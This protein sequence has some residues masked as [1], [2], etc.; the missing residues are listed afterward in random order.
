MKAIIILLF[1]FIHS[2]NID[3]QIVFEKVYSLNAVGSGMAVRQTTDGGFIFCGIGYSLLGGNDHEIFLVK[4]DSIGDTLWT[5]DF[6]TAFL[7]DRGHCVEQTIDGGYI[8]TGM[9]MDSNYMDVETFLIKTD[10]YGDTI[11]TKRYKAPNDMYGNSVVQTP[12]G[13]FV[14]AGRAHGIFAL[15]TNSFGDLLWMKIFQG[16]FLDDC[17]CCV[18]TKDGGLMLTGCIYEVGSG[19]YLPFLLKLDSL[20]N[21]LWAKTYNGPK[22]QLSHYV[23]QT[24]DGGFIL[25]GSSRD[26]LSASY[27]FLLKTDSIGNIS[28]AKQFDVSEPWKMGTAVQQTFDGGYIIATGSPIYHVGN[29]D[30]CLLKTD[31][32]GQLLWSKTYDVTLGEYFSDVRQTSDSGFIIIGFTSYSIVTGMC[33]IKTDQFGNSVCKQS[34]DAIINSYNLSFTTSN[35]FTSASSYTPQELNSNFYVKSGSEFFD[36]CPFGYEEPFANNPLLIFPNPSSGTFSLLLFTN[37]IDAKLEIFN[38]M[39]TKI[40]EEKIIGS[41][42][43]EITLTGM[44][45]AIYLLKV[46]DGHKYYHQKLMLECN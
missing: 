20:G 41:V 11:W 12:D 42:K 15:K 18:N 39:G 28:W 6:G 10:A 17:Y 19:D 7:Y 26:S 2:L 21:K 25:T 43:N 37:S 4:T 27:Q 38:L 24:Q 13:G 14:I 33:L 34:G 8:L 35:L 29:G 9:T 5:R 22:W 3:A 32:V 23:Q 31:S 1:I 46:Y 16:F 30:G 40:F 44:S 45:S 36:P